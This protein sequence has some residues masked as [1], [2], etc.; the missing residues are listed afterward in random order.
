MLGFEYITPLLREC[1]FYLDMH[2]HKNKG[3][4]HPLEHYI[5]AQNDYSTFNSK[6][7]LTNL[8]NVQI[9]IVIPP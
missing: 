9:Y 4:G 7:E 1:K 5:A 6:I 8:A 2:S 3:K